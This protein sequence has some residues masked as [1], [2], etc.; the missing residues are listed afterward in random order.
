M[1]SN[2][3]P[4]VNKENTLPKF[5][6]VPSRHS[7]P[8]DKDRGKRPLSRLEGRFKPRGLGIG[9]RDPCFSPG[10]SNRCGNIRVLGTQKHD[11]LPHP[12]EK[13]G[14]SIG[15]ANNGNNNLR[16]IKTR[17]HK[18][19]PISG[20]ASTV[21]GNGLLP[22]PSVAPASMNPVEGKV[23][24]GSSTTS[25]RKSSLGFTLLEH[26]ARPSFS[27]TFRLSNFRDDH[28]RNQGVEGQKHQSGSRFKTLSDADTGASII[29]GRRRVL[30][31]FIEGLHA[32]GKALI[33]RPTTPRP[34]LGKES[35]PLQASDSTSPDRVSA[36]G[37]VI[38]EFQFRDSCQESVIKGRT[39]S[40]SPHNSN[41][42]LSSCSSLHYSSSI[43]DDSP[44]DLNT[45]KVHRHKRRLPSRN[46]TFS[47]PLLTPLNVPPA[48]SNGDANLSID[49]NV[50]V[51]PEV[52][53][54]DCNSEEIVWAEIRIEPV[55]KQ[56]PPALAKE[57]EL[58]VVVIVDNS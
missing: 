17:N 34:D 39:P 33:S 28:E 50:K 10:Q 44:A 45:P 49:L 14:L 57:R 12:T 18:R 2:V 25:S 54:I 4:S 21:L 5:F 58:D 6:S 32:K 3:S 8:P 20:L 15:W 19:S 22:K 1:I 53:E 41:P 27:S 23:F 48:F 55:L 16:V 37:S 26:S 40:L 47:Q 52:D 29:K 7:S 9:L 43:P 42:F 11:D 51:I 38:H 30:S 13:P 31:R 56:C 24:R 46:W 35:P 36:E